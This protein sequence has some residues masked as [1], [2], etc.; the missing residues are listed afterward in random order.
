MLRKKP[1]K[2]EKHI[3][4]ATQT[5]GM[6]PIEASGDSRTHVADGDEERVR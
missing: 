3:W 1:Q 2:E 6:I 4:P 5:R